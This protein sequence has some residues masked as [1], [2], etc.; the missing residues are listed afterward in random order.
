MAGIEDNFLMAHEDIIWC[1][2]NIDFIASN[3][4]NIPE[5]VVG[6]PKRLIGEFAVVSLVAS[7]LI[8]IIAY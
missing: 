2:Q 7:L 3:N 8:Y 6:K 1:P 5:T 4:G